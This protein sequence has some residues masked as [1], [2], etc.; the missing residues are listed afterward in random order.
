MKNDVKG[1]VTYLFVVAVFRVCRKNV[2]MTITMRCKM[3]YGELLLHQLH[4]QRYIPIST[5]E[6][7]IS[8][9]SHNGGIT[10]TVPGMFNPFTAPQPVKFPG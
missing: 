8:L 10:V 2:G 3:D 9:C 1:E 5:N 4:E 6:C 7:S